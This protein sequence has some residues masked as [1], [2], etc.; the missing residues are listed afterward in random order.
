MGLHENAY[1]D[2]QEGIV[3]R[4]LEDVFK[5]AEDKFGE[6]GWKLCVSF[7]E[8][9]NE[10]V[11]DLF[12]ETSEPLK[13]LHYKAQ[14]VARCEVASVEEAIQLLCLANG[15]RHTRKT[16]LNASSSRSHAI[17]TV[18][19]SVKNDASTTESSLNLVDLA[20]SEGVKRTG[21]QGIALSEGNHINQ[22]L[23][24]VGKVLQALS[25][26]NKVIPYRDSVLTQVLQES[27]N[28]NSFITLLACVSP[29]SSNLNE[30]LSTLRFAHNAKQLKTTP[31]INQMVNEMKR[32]KTPSKYGAPLR[33]LQN[34]MTPGK[35]PFSMAG[36]GISTIKKQKQ[37]QFPNNTICTPNKRQRIDFEPLN[38][39]TFEI[40]SEPIPTVQEFFHPD[41]FRNAII[42]TRDS[43]TSLVSGANISA[44]TEI[45]EAPRNSCSNV[46]ETPVQLKFSISPLMR[47]LTNLENAVT[48]KFEKLHETM[49]QNQSLHPTSTPV[50]NKN[51]DESVSVLGLDAIRK[52]LQMIVRQEL[53]NFTTQLPQN[54]MT[55]TRYAN[56]ALDSLAIPDTPLTPSRVMG[57]GMRTVDLSNDI[58]NLV[59]TNND[60]EFK[61]PEPIVAPKSKSRVSKRLTN[62]LE[63]VPVRRSARL[64]SIPSRSDLVPAPEPLKKQTRR[65]N[66]PIKNK[67][68][69]SYFN[70]RESI[71][72]KV[73]K[74]KHIEAIF[75]LL[76][77]GSI[78]E[79]Q[80]L[81][82]I[83]HK[84]AYQIVTTRIMKGRYKSLKD[85]GKLPIWRG[86]QWETFL[87]ANN[88]K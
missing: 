20:G 50:T 81:P 41:N 44:S 13:S 70:S 15:A 68:I 24:A 46:V 3:H 85:I 61:V 76:N 35:R 2:E 12:S 5:G 17:F 62:T 27:L 39:T 43:V 45:D 51:T 19:L 78:K 36:V 1:E 52:E 22:G 30:T 84:T 33:N 71:D 54:P 31:Q 57:V 80:V 42:P 55:T 69:A 16:P 21:H 64:S 72:P 4:V 63:N 60:E 29:S 38:S 34:H 49:A 25:T 11:Y 83:G 47:R 77:T 65:R 86:K 74:S 88:L 66:V 18:R 6:N 75:E 9:Y 14:N 37:S 87:E 82:K 48:D 56:E 73:T 32:A 58:I 59:D 7:I 67:Q 10:K 53:H 26:G 79:L 28:L 40:P 23:L 8:I